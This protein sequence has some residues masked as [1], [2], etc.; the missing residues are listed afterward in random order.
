M[1]ENFKLDTCLVNIARYLAPQHG[2]HSLGDCRRAGKG[3]LESCWFSSHW[4]A[5]K[6]ALTAVATATE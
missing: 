3:L 4:D 5:D 1:L 6:T 2:A